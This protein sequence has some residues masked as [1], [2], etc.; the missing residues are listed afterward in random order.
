MKKEG[1]IGAATFLALAAVVGAFL[2]TGPKQ[3]ESKRTGRTV[4]SKR[5]KPSIAKH[6]THTLPGCDSLQDKLEQ[7]LSIKN[8]PSPKVC[9]ESGEA[10]Y[11]RL[12][13]SLSEKTSNLKLVIALLPDPVHT[14]LSPVFDQFATA[15][16]EGHSWADILWIFAF[17]GA[18][19]GRS[20]CSESSG[21][22][23]GA[24]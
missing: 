17:C 8:L 22:E 18:S 4:E 10:P 20:K 14:H 13:D 6:D 9:F 1:T 7:F 12:P 11:E 16:Q 23:P 15:L 3:G 21:F 19:A 2:Q 5:A 24:K